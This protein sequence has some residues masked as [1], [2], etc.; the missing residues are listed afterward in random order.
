MVALEGVDDGEETH[1]MRDGPDRLEWRRVVKLSADEPFVEGPVVWAET[2]TALFFRD[3]NYAVDPRGYCI[4]WDLAD[5]AL[6][7]LS[8]QLFAEW[9]FQGLRN[10]T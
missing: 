2:N 5:D 4:G 9:G 1:P 6:V 10:G 3:D 7:N 8:G